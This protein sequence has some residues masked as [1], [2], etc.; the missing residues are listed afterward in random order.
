MTGRNHWFAGM[1]RRVIAEAREKPNMRPEQRAA[2]ALDRL[3]E[4]VG[5]DR[6]EATRLL[7]APEA[8][9]PGP[10][11]LP[12]VIGRTERPSAIP[13]GAIVCAAPP[14]KEG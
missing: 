1:I 11:I 8:K 10:V 12:A 6:G 3:A 2:Y 13:E 9:C 7:L 14:R 5:M 4:I